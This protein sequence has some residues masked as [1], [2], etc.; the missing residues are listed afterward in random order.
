MRFI[1]P[2]W[3]KFDLDR[4]PPP[5][6]L[7]HFSHNASH[8]KAMTR[9]YHL[10]SRASV[11]SHLSEFLRH[12]N[13]KLNSSSSSSFLNKDELRPANEAPAMIRITVSFAE[14]LDVIANIN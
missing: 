10:T 7:V 3:Y 5:F 4:V 9:L 12:R 14:S 2:F 1:P 8:H 13:Q 6:Y 11:Y